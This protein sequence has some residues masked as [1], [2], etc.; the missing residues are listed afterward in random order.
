MKAFGL[1]DYFSGHL[2]SQGTTARFTAETY[3]AF[4]TTVLAQT[5]RPIMLIHDGARYHT[6]AATRAFIATHAA[7]LTVYQLP[8]MARLRHPAE[9]DEEIA[10]LKSEI[11]RL[12]RYGKI[13]KAAQEELD[14]AAHKFQ[15]EF[16]PRVEELMTSG[17]SQ[18]TGGRYGNVQ[19][20]PKNLAVSVPRPETR[21]LV[22]ADRLSTGTQ[23]LVY[24]ILRISLAR[25]MRVAL[26]DSVETPLCSPRRRGD[27]G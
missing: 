15:A 14:A 7:R 5:Q 20:D 24:L 21:E 12:E 2:F 16:A 3:C 4:L 8:T 27:G 17:L 23:D 9:L 1:I 19:V 6:A 10:V 25:L 11:Q 13:L 18:I 26:H 22:K